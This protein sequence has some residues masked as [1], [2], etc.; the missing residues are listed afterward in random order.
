[1]DED[2][3]LFAE[4][5]EK[6]DAERQSQAPRNGVADRTSTAKKAQLRPAPTMDKMRRADWD[7]AGPAR[8]LAQGVT[9]GFADEIEAGVRA[10]F[11][12]KSYGEIRDDVRGQNA[13]Y[14]AE[15]PVLNAALQL[16]GGV[17]GLGPA[18]RALSALTK[19]SRAATAVE[20]MGPVTRA[21]GSGAA[22]GAAAGV[23]FDEDGVSVA[24]VMLG[25]S[26]GAGAGGLLGAGAGALGA[27]R[28]FRGSDDVLESMAR[29]AAQKQV[30]RGGGP[31][32]L[33]MKADQARADGIP[34]RMLDMLPEGAKRTVRGARARGG[35]VADE[36]SDQIGARREGAFSRIE[37]LVKR[38]LGGDATDTDV[39]SKQIH[40]A[41]GELA[42]NSYG[43]VFDRGAEIKGPDLVRLLDNSTVKSAWD[44]VARIDANF[45]AAGEGG[46][47]RLDL[48]KDL[49]GTKGTGSNLPAT[50][51]SA[52]DRALVAY[53]SFKRN[54]KM[55]LRSAD[56][57]KRGLDD[58]IKNGL[59]GQT[60]GGLKGEARVSVM[61]LRDRLVGM[62]DEA[63]D[64]AIRTRA[65][66][67]ANEMSTAL[68]P[69][70]EAATPIGKTYREARKE[71]QTAMQWREALEEG[72]GFLDMS[73]QQLR[74]AWSNYT[75]Q[76]KQVATVG[77]RTK[78]LNRLGKGDEGRDR[79][80]GMLGSPE[81][82]EKVKVMFGKQADEFLSSLKAERKIADTD[83]FIRGGSQTAD[84]LADAGAGN[85]ARE[86][87]DA[88]SAVA[89]GAGGMARYAGR[90]V[91]GAMDRLREG[92]YGKV[93]D[94]AAK[95]YMQPADQADDFI[96]WLAQE[97]KR[98]PSR[99]PKAA[100][101]AGGF[102]GGRIR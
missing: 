24:D 78:V 100:V 15:H 86:V 11:S 102:L 97:S 89:Q 44:R 8:A 2:E 9:F 70:G 42:D 1:M 36:I 5:D 35:D 67:P 68:V 16:T 54:A 19:G 43:E 90:K 64:A 7:R 46:R 6:L 52:D 95:R 62:A 88:G 65:E 31:I 32:A 41:A 77:F 50:I 81:F 20:N 57:L 12:S 58:V 79:T 29:Q 53:D 85:M 93:A 76:E 56:A 73:P 51:G 98:T 22:G 34:V 87:L 37:S 47:Y 83:N 38:G 94:V 14:A 61:R 48:W 13:D 49:P 69:E 84:K 4:A 92:T 75:P 72:E 28:A 63:D 39:V 26:V 71:F 55:D 10:P 60:P 91:V 18:G 40:K 30:A 3:L 17:K 74:T 80:R 59:D 66:L 27:L 101:V 96:G 99:A 23:G 21:I 45:R 25:G 82:K 33:G